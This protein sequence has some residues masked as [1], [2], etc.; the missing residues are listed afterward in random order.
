[1]NADRIED[2]TAHAGDAVGDTACGAR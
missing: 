1:M 2:E